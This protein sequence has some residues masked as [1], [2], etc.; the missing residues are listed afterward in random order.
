MRYAE[1]TTNDGP[2]Y[3]NNTHVIY[4]QPAPHDPAKTYIQLTHP[5]PN[6]KGHII[7]DETP[8]EVILR[9]YKGME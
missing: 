8:V 1:F 4:V 6:D 9:L 2:V 7:V 5:R 3:I